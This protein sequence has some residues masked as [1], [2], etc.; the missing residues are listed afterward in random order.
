MGEKEPCSR[1]DEGEMTSWGDG[2]TI[3]FI[4]YPKT[5]T[6]II[7]AQLLP[8]RVH[9]LLTPTLDPQV[10]FLVL[11]AGKAHLLNFLLCMYAR[12]VAQ[13]YLT[14]IHGL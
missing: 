11:S 4:F 8:R 3:G 6:P 12:L 9:L 5:V 10:R 7:K 1:K 14:A 13:L 2:S